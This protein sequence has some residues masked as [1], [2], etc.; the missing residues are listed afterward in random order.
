KLGVIQCFSHFENEPKQSSNLLPNKRLNSQSRVSRFFFEKV[1]DDSGQR[2]KHQSTFRATLCNP[3]NQQS[4]CRQF[5]PWL[6]LPARQ[7]VSVLLLA[8]A[9]H[10]F[11]EGSSNKTA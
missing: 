2:T 5:P 7:I 4:L 9:S 11:H 3:A 1:S 10:N 6:V 8:R